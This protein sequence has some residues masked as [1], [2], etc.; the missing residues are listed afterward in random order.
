M[1]DAPDYTSDFVQSEPAEAADIP[2]LPAE[3]AVPITSRFL[4]VDVAA[5]RAK[6]LRRG[7]RLRYDI[8]PGLPH[9]V[10][11]ALAEVLVQLDFHAQSATLA[12][13]DF[14]GTSTNRS[15]LISAP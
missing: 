1:E 8:E 12:Q 7:A 6:Q 5:L 15:R 4:Y 9:R 11:H 10:A 13:A 3:P 2:Q 14:S